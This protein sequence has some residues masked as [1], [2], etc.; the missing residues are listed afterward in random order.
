MPGP[1]KDRLAE[2]RAAIGQQLKPG[3][4]AQPAPATPP[5]AAAE[6]GK[7]R[8]VAE[9]KAFPARSTPAPQPPTSTPTRSGRGM[10]FYLDDT[11]RKIIHRL[12]AWFG[13]QDR[14]VSD[15]QVIKSAIRLASIQPNSRLL[16]ICDEI[17]SADRRLQKSKHTKPPKET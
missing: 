10:Q 1:K 16:E 7:G 14:R 8:G 15:S 2:L 4:P 6:P 3:A 5:P 13:S 17:R 12:A 9:K 11:D